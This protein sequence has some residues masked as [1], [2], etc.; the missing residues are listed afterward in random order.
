MTWINI[1]EADQYSLDRPTGPSC[2]EA[3]EPRDFEVGGLDGRYETEAAVKKLQ[4]QSGI[5]IDGIVGPQTRPIMTGGAKD[6][7]AD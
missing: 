5:T 2:A 7:L 3:D 4:Q 6:P 1:D